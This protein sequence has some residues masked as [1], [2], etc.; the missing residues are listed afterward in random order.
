[1]LTAKIA[2]TL[3]QLTQYG[4]PPPPWPDWGPPEQQ[5][6]RRPPPP[7]WGPQME[8]CIYR[9]DCRGPRSQPPYGMP[10]YIPRPPRGDH[11]EDD[12]YD[13]L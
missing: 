10:P 11:Y 12:G 1:M 4:G 7:R 5:E 3:L 6:P 2:L 9:D 13:D 8:P